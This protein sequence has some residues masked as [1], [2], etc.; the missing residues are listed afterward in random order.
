MRAEKVC[1]ELR[2]A[3]ANNDGLFTSVDFLVSW[4][5]VAPKKVKYGR[6]KKP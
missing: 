1:Q 4:M 2:Y 5:R 6:A 3:V